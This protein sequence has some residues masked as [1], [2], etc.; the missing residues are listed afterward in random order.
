MPSIERSAAHRRAPLR[1]TSIDRVSGVP[2][3]Y[4]FLSATRATRIPESGV[5]KSSAPCS[6]VHGFTS[7]PR[8]SASMTSHHDNGIAAGA[9][10]A[11]TG[12]AA[13]AATARFVDG[14]VAVQRILRGTV[15]SDR[16]PS[17]HAPQLAGLENA[18]RLARER[19]PLRLVLHRVSLF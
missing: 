19:K 2:S 9:V 3:S 15:R 5:S 4:A 13:D 6:R 7:S 8:R 1:L 10:R 12:V 14:A 18:Q 16:P 11:A 17:R